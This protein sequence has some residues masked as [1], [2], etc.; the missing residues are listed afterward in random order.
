[1]DYFARIISYLFHPLLITTYGVV[2]LI[3]IDSQLYL[4]IPFKLKIILCLLT[5][6]FTFIFPVF[7]SWL[8]V[9][10]KFISSIHMHQKE[11]RNISYMITLVFYI[12]VYYLLREIQVFPVFKVLLLG[13]SV[14]LALAYIINF[15][16]KISAHMVGIGGLCGL[17]LAL[18]ERMDVTLVFPLVL[19]IAGVVGFSRL[20]LNAHTEAQVYVGFLLGFIATFSLFLIA[21]T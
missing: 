10:T 17:L 15:Y 7:N 21:Y 5:L 16:W 2:L 4:F 20:V 3:N 19:F 11:E 12:A 9:K 8:L 18:S 6:T 13:A 14:S 1:M